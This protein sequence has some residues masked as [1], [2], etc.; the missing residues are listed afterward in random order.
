[1]D[2]AAQGPGPRDPEIPQPSG[3]ADEHIAAPTAPAAGPGTADWTR[4]LTTVAVVA[5]RTPPAVE[6]EAETEPAAEPEPEPS[7]EPEP[8]PE[9][10]AELEPAPE[11]VAEA[12]VAEPEPEPEAVVEP[13]AEAEAEAEAEDEADDDAFDFD[14]TFRFGAEPGDEADTDDDADED[15]PGAPPADAAEADGAD[16]VDD[17]ADDSAAE[18][19]TLI[20]ESVVAPPP[21]PTAPLSGAKSSDAE[22]DAW[23]ASLGGQPAE[24]APKPEAAAGA[25]GAAS[26]TAAPDAA[27]TAAAD[28]DAAK[29]ELPRRRR[30]VNPWFAT[31]GVVALLLAGTQLID[32]PFNMATGERVPVSDV[33]RMSDPE[34]PADS[35][36]VNGGL[37]ANLDLPPLL[38]AA[39]PGASTSPTGASPT[40]KT[41]SG[42]ATRTGAQ[43]PAPNIQGANGIPQIVLLSYQQAADYLSKANPKCKLPWQLLAAIGRVESGH[44]N[45]GQ[46]STAG[47]TLS[48]ILGPRLDGSRNTRAI[49]DTDQ[50]ALDFDR[51]FDRAVGPMQFIPTS[52]KAYAMDGNNDKVADPQNVFDASRTAARYLCAGS[53]D[54]STPAGLD[55]AIFSYNQSPEYVTSVKAW[56]TYY[57]AGVRP[58]PPSTGGPA[59]SA[60]PSKSPSKSPTPTKSASKSPTKSGS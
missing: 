56:K 38:P 48:P 52:W 19:D 23:L 53:R 40:G 24:L 3:A 43:T 29:D 13:P 47:T 55:K 18:P 21:A 58:I 6:A 35:G 37:P 44:A 10:E 14:R 60:S 26:E 50:G 33:A 1:M 34:P 9:P 25:A 59:T 39:A 7:S 4:N 45:G 11:P 49:P 17:D 42:S 22:L 54:L 46:V 27:D 16:A 57:E 30:F 15:E 36:P 20:F 41:P 51:E 28:A 31:A 8:G 12:P 2:E 5:P 32:D